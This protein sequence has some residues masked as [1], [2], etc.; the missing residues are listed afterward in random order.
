MAQVARE[1]A[2]VDIGIAREMLPC[3]SVNV[4]TFVVTLPPGLTEEQRAELDYWLRE[5]SG[6]LRYAGE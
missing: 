5:V 1:V 4:S 2:G 3:Q 6:N